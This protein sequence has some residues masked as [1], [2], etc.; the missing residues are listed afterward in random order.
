MT[1]PTQEDF[2][3][4]VNSDCNRQYKLPFNDVHLRRWKHFYGAL[5][6]LCCIVWKKLDAHNSIDGA[7][8]KH[9]MWALYFL[10][11]YGKE[12]D[13]SN[14]AG[15][16]D[17]K[18]F[19][20]WSHTFVEAIS[21]LESSVVSSFSF[22]HFHSTPL[23]LFILVVSSFRHATDNMGRTDHRRQ[24]IASNNRWN[25]HGRRNWFQ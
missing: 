9:L 6:D 1:C 22:M 10:K 21:F 17:E 7:Q 19:R 24:P 4:A 3:A 11:V 23:S 13:C 15:G 14:F 5:P 12:E 16:V 20:K 25:R 8:F 2:V 18:T